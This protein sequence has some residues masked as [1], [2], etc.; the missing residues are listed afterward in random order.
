MHLR[1]HDI[2]SRRHSLQ[3]L[4]KPPPAFRHFMLD[5]QSILKALLYRTPP[6][7]KERRIRGSGGGGFV[8][9]GDHARRRT[10]SFGGSCFDRASLTRLIDSLSLYVSFFLVSFFRLGPTGNERRKGEGEGQKRSIVCRGSHEGEK[11]GRAATR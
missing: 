8:Q 3:D 10:L 1:A 4:G 9:R 11:V 6:R 7:E 2:L 5:G